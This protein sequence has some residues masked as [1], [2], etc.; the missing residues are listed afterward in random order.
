VAIRLGRVL[1]WTA[2]VIAC[3]FLVIGGVVF[4]NFSETG[5]LDHAIG[6]ALIMGWGPAVLLYAF[7]RAARYVL[8]NE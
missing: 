3:V 5:T 7:G 6:M 4:R 2:L 1:Y 8:S